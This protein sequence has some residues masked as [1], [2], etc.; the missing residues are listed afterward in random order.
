MTRLLTFLCLITLLVSCK[1][2]PKEEIEP[3]ETISEEK[4]EATIAEKIAQANGFDYWQ[5]ANIVEYTFNV[6]RGNSHFE[7]SW[8][9]RPKSD[10]VQ[11]IT[12]KDTVNYNR[13]SIDS[14]SMAADQSFINDK[15]WLLVPFQLV[16][17]GGTTIS[18]PIKEAAPISKTE[19]NKITLTYG[20]EGGYTPGDAYDLYY[21]EDFIINEW[22]FR[23]GNS[24]EPTMAT[25]FEDY[26]VFKGVKIAK[27]HKTAEGNFHLYFSN[28]SIK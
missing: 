18:E 14:L 12:D 24:E 26:E 17:D 27:S 8:S 5:N 2:D 10:Q 13:K 23:K 28:I 6:D 25:T 11:L 4:K 9:W 22:V 3:I 16:W 7:R 19:M 21:G 1:Q 20:N 15:F